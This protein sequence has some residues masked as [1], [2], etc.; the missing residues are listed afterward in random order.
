MD[1]WIGYDYFLAYSPELFMM[2]Q[3]ALNKCMLKNMKKIL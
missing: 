2:C 1:K 3:K